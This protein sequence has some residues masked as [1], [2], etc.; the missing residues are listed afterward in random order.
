MDSID[1]FLKLY[2][3]KFNKGYPDINNEQDILLL[4]N[5]L[6]ELNL[7]IFLKEAKTTATEDL[8]EIFT[9]MFVAGHKLLPQEE[10]FTADWDKEVNLSKLNK[11]G[12]NIIFIII[13]S[14]CVLKAIVAIHKNGARTKIAKKESIM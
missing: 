3:Y 5:I 13:I 6:K 14:I 10:F 7:E 4:E 11:V 8:H 12:L 1:K 2:S 9:A